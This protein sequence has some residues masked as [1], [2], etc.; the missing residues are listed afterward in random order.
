MVECLSSSAIDNHLTQSIQMI[1]DIRSRLGPSRL[2]L[3]WPLFACF[4]SLNSQHQTTNQIIPF[5]SPEL[6]FKT[7]LYSFIFGFLLIRPGPCRL[8]CRGWLQ[9]LTSHVVISCCCPAQSAGSDTAFSQRP[10]LREVNRILLR[11]NFDNFSVLTPI[12]WT[13]AVCDST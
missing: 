13:P 9:L 1:I 3:R 2:T 6:Y 12:K 4:P 11:T 8:P 5:L 10:C 7:H